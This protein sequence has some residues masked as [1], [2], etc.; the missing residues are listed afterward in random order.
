MR[1]TMGKMILVYVVFQS[2]AKGNVPP[3]LAMIVILAQML[4]LRLYNE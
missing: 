3:N 1:R 2:A 4:L